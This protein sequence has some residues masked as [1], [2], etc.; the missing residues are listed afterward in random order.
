M[1]AAETGR[2]G[3]KPPFNSGRVPS[4]R[5]R[6]GPPRSR[7][8]AAV[9]R[10]GSTRDADEAFV[11]SGAM[12]LT[13]VDQVAERLHTRTPTMIRLSDEGEVIE[14]AEEVT[15]HPLRYR[16]NAHHMMSEDILA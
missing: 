10:A 15:G 5:E 12:V 1:Y 7:A 11:V 2:N 8:A 9:I 6:R 16:G 4:R 3:F 13:R 14:H